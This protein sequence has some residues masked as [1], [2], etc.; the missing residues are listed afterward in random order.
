MAS[1]VFVDTDVILDYLTDRSPF[2]HYSSMIFDLH[3]RKEIN[4]HISALSVNNIFY[5][6]RKIIGEEKALILLSKLIEDIEII[7]TTKAEIRKALHSDF[8]DFEDAIQYSTA[9]TI[10][11]MS[12]IITRDIK[13]Y[14]KSI[15]AVFTP[16]IF[17][18]TKF[19]KNK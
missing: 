13:D 18:K 16:E 9:L 5:I 12:S 10:S 1:K 2:A 17:I 4:I 19:P 6:A 7:G 11:G 15:I 3:E 14:R 8:K